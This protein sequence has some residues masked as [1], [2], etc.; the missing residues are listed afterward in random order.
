[1]VQRRT[2]TY[3]FLPLRY[4]NRALRL[5]QRFSKIKLISMV[6]Y[7]LLLSIISKVPL[8]GTYI[9]FYF[10]LIHV[11]FNVLFRILAS[12]METLQYKKKCVFLKQNIVISYGKLVNEF[13]T[14][15]LLFYHITCCS[16]NIT[17]FYKKQSW[18]KVK[19]LMIL[20]T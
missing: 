12:P 6:R 3:T 5:I 2:C 19:A 7:S 14:Q 1:M 18:C 15:L 11:H 4:Y 10:E 9:L 20:K 8:N 13:Y 17:T 16:P